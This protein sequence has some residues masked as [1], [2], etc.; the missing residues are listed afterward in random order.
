[1]TT[2]RET[3]YTELMALEASAAYKFPLSEYEN[4]TRAWKKGEPFFEAVGWHGA[5]TVVKLSRIEC[6]TEW[7][8]EALELL[9][10]ERREQEKQD[11][12]SGD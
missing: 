4:A 10:A 6:V 7:T 12:I 1:M 9:Y 3:G 2:L 11:A 5:K 8:P